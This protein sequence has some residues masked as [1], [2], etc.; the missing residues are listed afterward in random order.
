MR[1]PVATVIALSVSLIPGWASTIISVSAG[2]AG[3]DETDTLGYTTW[4]QSS[5]YTGV[6]ITAELA[7]FSSVEAHGTA[8]LMTQ[9][10]P[11]TTSA[12]EVTAPAAISTSDFGLSSIT[13]FSGLT[14]PAGTYYLV[15]ASDGNLG[16]FGWP[17]PSIV[18]PVTPFITKDSG[19]TTPTEPNLV[20]NNTA[21]VAS[22]APASDFASDGGAPD[23]GCTTPCPGLLLF[24]ATG[25][26]ASTT[27]V[28]EPS[29][30]TLVPVA[31]GLGVFFYRRRVARPN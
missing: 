8:Y 22:F 30:G 16:W 14:L 26:P 23:F 9:I 31:V 13:L 10:G 12:D 25:T 27:V 2:T 1:L 15:I 28:P 19:V 20:I 29:T 5:G 24:A 18:A 4:T 11:G 3:V 17:D 6:T 7:D 21:D